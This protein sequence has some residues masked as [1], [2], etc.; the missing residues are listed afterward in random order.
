MEEI[1]KDVDGY[2]GLYKVSNLGRVLGLRRKSRKNSDNYLSPATNRKGYN[3]LCFTKDKVKKTV[4]VYR[5]VAIA[6]IENPENKATVNH[7][8]GIKTDDRAENLE[9]M[10]NLENMRHGYENGLFKNRL[11]G[12]KK[13]MV[14]DIELGIYYDRLVE[15]WRAYGKRCSKTKFGLMVHGKSIHKSKYLAI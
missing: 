5:I 2:E 12:G 4:K 6:F 9:W 11:L 10:T 8:N 7:K 14:F 3:T 13:T 15:A 1:W